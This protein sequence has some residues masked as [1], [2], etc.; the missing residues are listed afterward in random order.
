M[1]CSNQSLSKYL[2]PLVICIAIDTGFWFTCSRDSGSTFHACSMASM[3]ALV[4]KL[5]LVRIVLLQEVYVFWTCIRDLYPD[6][7]SVIR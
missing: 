4:L 7:V 6:V 5:T 1:D 2:T 3:A